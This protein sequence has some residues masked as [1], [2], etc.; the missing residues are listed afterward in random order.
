MVTDILS[1]IDIVI[2]QEECVDC[3]VFQIEQS[4]RTPREH[5]GRRAAAQLDR[6]H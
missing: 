5:S 1:Y 6:S 4:E 2:A 3:S